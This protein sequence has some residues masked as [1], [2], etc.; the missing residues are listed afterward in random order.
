MRTAIFLLIPL[1]AAC[2]PA[3]AAFE[4]SL[5]SEQQDTA[6]YQD[7]LQRARK[8]IQ[9][10]DFDAA[11]EYLD[12]AEAMGMNLT[13]LDEAQALYQ[14]KKRANEQRLAEQKRR[15]EEAARR[16]AAASARSS[17]PSGGGSGGT[18]SLAVGIRVGGVWP[19]TPD[20][21][22]VR[23]TRTGSSYTRED[24]SS[25]WGSGFANF[26]HLK[27]GEYTLDITAFEDG[28]GGRSYSAQV[29]V[30]HPGTGSM[31]CSV[32]LDNNYVNCN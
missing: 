26:Y 24:S 22:T 15:E 11:R 10:E 25:D 13:A 28:G 4:I 31:M 9:R 30:H 18:G 1:L 12:R 17:A 20:R 3:F 8:A 23:A 6:D 27:A 7:A 19:I 29:R 32:Y 5:D 14:K 21:F 16:Q 2:P